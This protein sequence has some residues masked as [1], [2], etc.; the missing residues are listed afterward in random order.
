M[1]RLL[2]HLALRQTDGLMA[3]FFCLLGVTLRTPGHST[4]SRRS[5]TLESVSKCCVPPDGPIHLLIDKGLKFFGAR[6]WLQ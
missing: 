3:S 4:L 6:E 2:F 5:K 1:L